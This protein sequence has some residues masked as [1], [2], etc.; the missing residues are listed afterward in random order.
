MD[1][2]LL[3]THDVVIA[4]LGLAE[5]IIACIQVERAHA[6]L[7]RVPDSRESQ[8]SDSG[9]VNQPKISCEDIGVRPCLANDISNVPSFGLL[10][11]VLVLF[12]NNSICITIFI[13]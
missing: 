6:R 4:R 2:K 5:A 11:V 7:V 3:A 12:L 1:S 10:L 13:S 9:A 8:P